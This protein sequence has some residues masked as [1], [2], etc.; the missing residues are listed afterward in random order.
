[1][2][3]KFNLAEPK[4]KEMA[5]ILTT[6]KVKSSILIATGEA[7]MNVVKS[8]RNIDGIKTTPAALLNVADLLSHRTLLMTVDAIHK[9]EQLWGKK[10]VVEAAQNA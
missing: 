4:T 10:E 2:I 9:I 1:V 5:K 7:D 8:C 6:L 3:D